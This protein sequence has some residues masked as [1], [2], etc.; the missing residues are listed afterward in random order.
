MGG[1][2]HGTNAQEPTLGELLDDPLVRLLMMRDG[3]TRCEVET[4][5]MRA[6]RYSANDADRK[7][8]IACR[9]SA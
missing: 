9:L 4:L 7:F 5:M 3:V 2:M 1:E 8:E 6:Q